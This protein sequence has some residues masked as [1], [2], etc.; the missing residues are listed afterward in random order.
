MKKN[1]IR[2]SYPLPISIF[3]FL[4]QNLFANINTNSAYLQKYFQRTEIL[5]R[6]STPTIKTSYS[7]V[8]KFNDEKAVSLFHNYAIYISS[9]E[10]VNDI[11]VYTKNPQ[12]NGKMKT[13]DIKDFKMTNA[14]SSSIFY[15]DEKEMN[16]DFLGLTVGSE[17]YVKYTTTTN[18][19]HFTEPMIFSYYLPVQEKKFELI[20]PKEVNISFIEK[21]ILPTTYTFEKNIKKSETIYTWLAKDIEE[22]KSLESP[23]ARM[24]YLPH[25]LFKIDDYSVKEKKIAVSKTTKDY[26][27]WIANSIKLI[28]N[29]PDE[30]LKLLADSMTQ[31]C[32]TDKEKIIKVYD[33]VKK[34]IRYVAFENGM[35]GL[36]PREAT[37]V[38]D[39]RYG[40]CKDMSSLQNGLLKAL[41]ISA[42][43]TLLGTRKIPYTYDEVPLKNTDN[44]MIAS[45]KLDGK[46]YFLDATDPNGFYDIPSG[47]IQGKQAL[48]CKSKS[49]FELVTIPITASSVNTFKEENNLKLE[50]ATLNVKSKSNFKGLFGN[51]LA[52]QI[53][54]LSEN[55]KEDYGKGL[56]KGISNNAQL[57][58]FDID[59]KDN[60]YEMGYT[61]D[62][63]INNYAKEVGDELYLNILLDKNLSS[64]SIKE[65]NRTIPYAFAYNTNYEVIYKLYI[66]SQY[67]VSYLPENFNVSTSSYGGSIMYTKTDTEITCTQ[68]IFINLPNLDMP[69]SEFA[70][71]NNFIKQL[72][73]AYKESIALKK[74]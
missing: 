52:N 37:L 30:K 22:E 50:N 73:K 42:Y 9:F 62:Y 13:I 11:E 54:Y 71:W 16:I 61:L 33:W 57:M 27:D 34:N 12:A 46:W 20:V 44:H 40:D 72:N 32:K 55:D 74:I 45:V 39:R 15:D 26:F 51:S 67:K 41:N 1:I 17:A 66:P 28:N 53:L 43:L 21:N 64:M 8:F 58:L 47:Q 56:I 48:I 18:E 29:K 31:N 59:K 19:T 7:L 3:F 63:K 25:V 4:S 10:T 36:I 2:F 60:A 49:E 70:T 65:P 6:D 14:R 69:A 68:K 38:C 23:P 35:E 5:L 24:A